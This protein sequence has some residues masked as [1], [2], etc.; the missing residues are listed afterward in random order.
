M[1]SVQGATAG[2]LFRPRIHAPA[3]GCRR[4]LSSRNL[5]KSI[6]PPI[7]RTK[8]LPFTGRRRAVKEG[9]SCV[10]SRPELKARWMRWSS[11]PSRRV[12]CRKDACKAK[13]RAPAASFD[14]SR[15]WW[16]KV[17][18]SWPASTGLMPA[19]KP[20]PRPDLRR[21]L[22][23][24]AWSS[25]F[26]ASNFPLAFSVAGGDTASAFALG[27]PVIVKAHPAHPGTGELVAGAI[28][29]GSSGSVRAARGHFLLYPPRGRCTGPRPRPASPHPRG[30]FHRAHRR[31]RALRHRG[32]APRAHPGLCGKNEQPICSHLPGAM[33]DAGRRSPKA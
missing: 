24:S 29:P 5:T 18:G 26:G 27:N 21:M 16:K 28:T 33:R 9:S 10:P 17:H 1:D 13:L 14:S 4:T 22:V 3:R 30:G 7:W 11:A 20:A 2:Q 23:P 8:L 12:R 6:W 31:T 19:R 15:K 32:G 25:V